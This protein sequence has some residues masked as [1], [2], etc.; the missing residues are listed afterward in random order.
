[1]NE[2][3]CRNCL[4]LPV[5]KN[6]LFVGKILVYEYILKCPIIKEHMKTGDNSDKMEE[7]RMFYKADLKHVSYGAENAKWMDL[8]IFVTEKREK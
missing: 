8:K 7:I 2:I 4:S 5:C 6:K 3:P 1:M